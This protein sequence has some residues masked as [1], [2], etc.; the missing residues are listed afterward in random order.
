MDWLRIDSGLPDHAKI[1]SLADALG[2]GED[3]AIAIVTRLLC[4]TARTRE[5]GEHGAITPRQLC[6]GAR[7]QVDGLSPQ[8][9]VKA[10]LSSGW[11]DASDDQLCVHGWADAQSPMIASRERVRAYRERQKEKRLSDVTDTGRERVP[12]YLP[13]DILTTPPYPPFVPKGG[14]RSNR[15]AGMTDEALEALVESTRRVLRDN[16]ADATAQRQLQ[17]A[18]AEQRRRNATR[19]GAAP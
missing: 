14:N 11:L 1:A 10:L 17:T 3:K 15:M 2:V 12:T 8:E 19:A 18:F 4:W 7:L 5:T 16:P 6:Y 13:T 9:I